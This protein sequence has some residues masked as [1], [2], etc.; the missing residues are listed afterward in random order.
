MTITLLLVGG[1]GA[2]PDQ[3]AD[4]GL[5]RH[6]RAGRDGRRSTARTAAEPR[7]GHATT[8]RPSFP[9]LAIPL[10]I[11]AG[12]IMNASAISRRLI[13][14]AIV[15]VRLDPR[16]PRARLDRRVAVLRRDFRLGG[17]RRRRARL[18]P[19][20]GDEEQGLS[21]GARRRGD[22][23]GGDAGGDHPAVDPDDP[24]RGDGARPRSCSCSSPASCPASSARSADGRAASGAPRRYNLPREAAFSS[25]ARAGSTR[26]RSAV[27]VHAA[28]HHPRRHLRRRRHRDRRRRLAVLAATRR[29]RLIYRELDFAELRKACIDGGIQTA[30]VM[31]LVASSR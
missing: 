8:A 22:V 31:L 13:A 10:F 27:G 20:P 7:P 12:A 19:D 3:R 5:A 1:A 14:F 15:A 6:R 18:D 11:L 28:D 23:V 29:R 2:G 9:L 25:I 24:L 17:R 26:T 16:R 4:R 21:E 30:V